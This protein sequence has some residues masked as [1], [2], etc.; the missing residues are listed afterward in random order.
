MYTK[1]E[2]EKMPIP[3]L[4]GIADELGVKV[5]QNDELETVIYAILDKAAE[6]SAAG[7]PTPKRKRTRIA[8][9]NSKVYTVKDGEGESLDKNSEKPAKK[10][11]K[12]SL[13]A[14]IAEQAAQEAAQDTAEE[15]PAPKKRGRKSKKELE[16]R[17]LLP[18][19][20]RLKRL[21]TRRKRLLSRRPPMPKNLQAKQKWTSSLRLSPTRKTRSSLRR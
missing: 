1:E 18:R 10:S 16:L 4:M 5:S 6:N 11:K 13:E 19:L 7:V 17:R 8:K 14:V 3:E 12:P 9:D 21:P 20:L 15:K 2:L